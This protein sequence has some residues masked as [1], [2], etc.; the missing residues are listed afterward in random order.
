MIKWKHKPSGYCP[1]QAEG[2]FMGHY[3]YFRSRWRYST[4]EF[5]KTEEDWNEDKIKVRYTLWQTVDPFAA[6]WMNHTKC[7]LLIWWACFKFM[8]KIK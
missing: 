5:S 4:I 8:L 3:F 2:W 7:R 6:G 1:V